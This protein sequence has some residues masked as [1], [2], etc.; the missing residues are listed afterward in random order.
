LPQRK[1]LADPK[2]VDKDDIIQI[3]SWFTQRGLSCPEEWGFS[4]I[5]LIIHDTAAGFLYLTNSKIA[6]IEG[7]ATNPKANPRYK[8]WA[9]RIITS[10]LM[11]RAQNT[12]GVK[13]LLCNT[14]RQSIRRMAQSFGFK[15]TGSHM[16]F[17]KHLND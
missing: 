13:L 9:L 7:Y 15:D 3:Q 4:S 6:Y 14:Q 2:P 16:T 17:C 1:V 8:L 11:W 12:Y 10:T 5:G